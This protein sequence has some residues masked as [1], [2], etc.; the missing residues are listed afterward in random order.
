[1]GIVKAKIVYLKIPSISECTYTTLLTTVHCAN[2]N[3]IS[4]IMI[5]W[6]VPLCNALNTS[7]LMGI[8][9]A[10]IVY[11]KIPSISEC[12]HTTLFT[13]VHRAN[14]NYISPICQ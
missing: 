8:V 1:M 10:K 3:Y 2:F 11:L 4:P 7:H 9:R 14:F 13:T 6:P 5:A 12:T